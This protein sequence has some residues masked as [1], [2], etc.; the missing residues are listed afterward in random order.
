MVLWCVFEGGV[1]KTMCFA[2]ATCDFFTTAPCIKNEMLRLLCIL[3]VQFSETMCF[4]IA[5]CDCF[6]TA[7]CI[8]IEMLLLLC[9]YEGHFSNTMCF[10]YVCQVTFC[11]SSVWCKRAPTLEHAAG[12]SGSSGFVRIVRIWPDRC[13]ELR[14]RPSLPHPPGARM[15]GVITNSLK[16]I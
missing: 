9:V 15:T 12:S 10:S 8:K 5:A 11:K 4:T 16:L 7:P 1:S 13:S 6:T 14:L 3:K 2:I